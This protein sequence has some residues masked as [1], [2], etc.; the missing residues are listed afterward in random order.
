MQTSRVIAIN[1]RQH[2]QQQQQQQAQVH[3][4]LVLLYLVPRGTAGG[5]ALCSRTG[6]T[7]KDGILTCPAIFGARIIT[8]LFCHI[9]RCFSAFFRFRN[10]SSNGIAISFAVFAGLIRVTNTQTDRYTDRHTDLATS[11]RW[12]RSA[13]KRTLISNTVSY[14]VVKTWVGIAHSHLA[15]A[16]VIR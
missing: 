11:L 13:L 3:G 16:T 8:R 6:S 15:L 10:F 5:G 1:H 9:D 7:L 12:L 14:R 2:N 4:H